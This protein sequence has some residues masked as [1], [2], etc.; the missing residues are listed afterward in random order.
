MHG[1]H[2]MSEN[3]E[4]GSQTINLSGLDCRVHFRTWGAG[5][6]TLVIHGWMH[7]SEIWS[8]TAEILCPMSKVV[9]LDLP[10][11]GMSPALHESVISLDSYAELLSDFMN[12]I[13]KDNAIC[14]IAA[15]SLGAVLVLKVLR[16]ACFPVRLL[17]LSGCPAYGLPFAL[18]AINKRGLISK[19]LRMLRRLPAPLL[20]ACIRLLSLGT[21]YNLK[22]VKP[23][24]VRGVS[25]AD[26]LSAEK[27][28]S[29][30]CF[31]NEADHVLGGMQCPHSI[32]L[33]GQKD[34]IVSESTA[35]RLATS[36]G[37][38]YL[39]VPGVSHTPMVENPSAY[40]A[41]LISELKKKAYEI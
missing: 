1:R 24:I 7:S 23:A 6:I 5:P 36:L 8:E 16:H 15:D 13:S 32:I 4:T 17:L 33:R 25:Q 3:I 28:F 12:A 40:C 20:G 34:R 30:L 2:N 38:A 19:G 31:I 9:A 41:A 10:G 11:F 29:D 27:L 35:R 26:P 22:N 21:V 39:E 14:C 37:G 18:R